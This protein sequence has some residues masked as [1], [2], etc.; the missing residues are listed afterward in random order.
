MRSHEVHIGN[1]KENSHLCE[2]SAGKSF[3]RIHAPL[4]TARVAISFESYRI[5]GRCATL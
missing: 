2:K 3:T 5:S 4:H 1:L